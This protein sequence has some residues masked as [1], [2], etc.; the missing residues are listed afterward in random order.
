MT[1]LV[2]RSNARNGT[3]ELNLQ[4]KNDVSWSR[5]HP[6]WSIREASIIMSASCLKVLITTLLGA[7]VLPHAAGTAI[8][9]NATAFTTT[10]ECSVS[11]SCVMSPNY[12]DDYNRND[13]CLIAANANGVLDVQAFDLEFCSDFLTVNGVEYTGTIGPEG[14]AVQAGQTTMQ[15]TSDDSSQ[16]SGFYICLSLPPTPT[17]T[18]TPMPSLTRRPTRQPTT[19]ATYSVST[20][21]ELR[22]AV[23]AAASDNT[24]VVVCANITLSVAL[25][26]YNTPDIIFQSAPGEQRYAL[27]GGGRV[28]IMRIGGESRVL[29]QNLTLRGG[30]SE[31]TASMDVGGAINVIG[32]GT[33]L[34][35][36]GSQLYDCTAV[37]GGAIGCFSG[38]R[39]DFQTVSFSNCSARR[40]YGGAV[41]VYDGSQAVMM[42]MMTNGSQPF[43]SSSLLLVIFLLPTHQ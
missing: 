15:F 14:V 28:Q 24:T 27:S 29:V 33:S 42:K 37:Y 34:K 20:E 9:D 43:S 40:Y 23:I 16:A 26:L 12:P 6:T 19:R 31:G 36:A 25:D 3:S 17:P 32:E 10:G 38:A 4:H 18:T 1:F 21:Q 13:D 8:G 11:G 22:Q 39:C 2:V 41:I 30:Y 5:S 35:V 7:L